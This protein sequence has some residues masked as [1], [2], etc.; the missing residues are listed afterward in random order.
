MTVRRGSVLAGVMA[1]F[2]LTVSVATASGPLLI[3]IPGFA[4]S[5]LQVGGV[6]RMNDGGAIV[7]GSQQD[8]GATGWQPAIIRLHVDG[9][10]DLG[11]GTEGISRPRLGAGMAATAL[12][13]DPHSGDAWVATARLKGK[14]AIVALNGDGDRATRFAHGGILWRGASSAPVALAWRA[15]R[16]LVASGGPPCTGCRISVV[17]PS[18]GKSIV[19]GQL[20]PDQLGGPRC[21]DGAITSAVLTGPRIAQLAFQ[22]GQHC[23]DRIVTISLTRRGSHPALRQT[24]YIP[25]GSGT[26]G[27]ALVAASG[28]DLCV[29]TASPASSAFGPLI[30]RRHV[31]VSS[32]APGG[33]LIAL[34][35]LGSGACAAL[36]AEAHHP[37]TV[38][39]QASIQRR[40]ATLDT[41]PRSLQALGMFRCHA[42]LV[43]L[44]ARR[45]GRQSAGAV[46]TIT[47][48]RGP[49]GAASTAAV[50]PAT[51]SRCQ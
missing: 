41:V 51:A 13:I 30:A 23:G 11:Y 46:V 18:T 5:A 1:L 12:A 8:P 32:R 25:L 50:A 36:I 49:K 34:V 44:G 3:P 48:R 10:I 2:L 17:D 45:R 43:V 31:V 24:R 26:P 37:T 33:R 7:A 9:S 29:A 6:A 16:L 28:S 39:T 14:S 47:V 27:E 20:A 19:S 4:G 22:G 40:R 15:G 42:H 38:V 21:T 35:A